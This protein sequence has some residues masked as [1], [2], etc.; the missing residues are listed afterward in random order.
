MFFRFVCYTERVR[1]YK[2]P[3]RGWHLRYIEQP[4]TLGFQFIQVLT[5]LHRFTMFI[6]RLIFP[7]QF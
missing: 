6:Y 5:S 7:G 1:V 2:F 4:L 3:S